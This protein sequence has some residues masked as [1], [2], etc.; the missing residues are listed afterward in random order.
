MRRVYWPWIG[1]A[2]LL[3][4]DCISYHPDTERCGNGIKE[5]G[6]ECDGDDLGFTTC[7]SLGFPGGLLY[8]RPNCSFE[9]GTCYGSRMDCNSDEDCVSYPGEKRCCV[10][11]DVG[12]FICMDIDPNYECGD[13][14]GGCGTSCTGT[15]DS[16]CLPGYPC[17]SD[18]LDDPEAICSKQCDTD[19]DCRDCEHRGPGVAFA[20]QAISGGDRYCLKAA[21]QACSRHGDCPEGE[22]CMADVVDG[23]LRGSCGRQGALDPGAECDDRDEPEDLPYRE[24]CAALYCFHGMCPEV[25]MLDRDC[26]EAMTCETVVLA[27]P[28]DQAID[29]CV[30]PPNGGSGPGDPCIFG[31]VN[32]RSEYCYESLA[33]LGYDPVQLDVPCER[34]ADCLEVLPPAENPDCTAEGLCGAS[35]CSPHCDENECE[36]GFYPARVGDDCYCIPQ[37]VGSSGPGEPCPHMGANVHAD[38]CQ[39]GLVCL[40]YDPRAVDVP[41][42]TASD[43]TDAL[44]LAENPDCTLF[45]L[46]GASFCA[47]PCDELGECE[48]GFHPST[49][50]GGDGCYCIPGA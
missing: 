46:C 29:M 36:E 23:L 13:G 24:R 18:S 43:C 47:P 41:C 2:C 28:P 14:A 9:T 3:V 48:P 32:T 4:G 21:G 16:A 27:E 31:S 50:I 12:F 49:W 10:E 33:C 37:D 6:E 39:A 35:F 8:C 30:G 1:L 5:D 11:V 25:C 15:S 40:G 26:P 17:L 38:D 34:D 19:A 22:V 44:P 45:M 7:E 42:E 20:C